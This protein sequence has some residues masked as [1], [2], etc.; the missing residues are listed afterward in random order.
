MD[1]IKA[2]WKKI[3]KPKEV[4]KNAKPRIQTKVEKKICKKCKK[5]KKLKYFSKHNSTKDGHSFWCKK[6]ARAKYEFDKIHKKP[7]KNFIAC[8]CHYCSKDFHSY[9]SNIKRNGGKYCSRSCQ[10][11]AY[12]ILKTGIKIGGN[13]SENK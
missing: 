13:L 12:S 9:I 4:K 7:T 11:K 8:K 2:L 5:E 1:F 10:H 3:F 6:C